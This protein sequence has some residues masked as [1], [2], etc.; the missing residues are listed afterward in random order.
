MRFHLTFFL[1]QKIFIPFS[2]QYFV[3]S[4]IYKVLQSG[5]SEFARFLHNEGIEYKGKSYKAFVFSQLTA[6]RFKVIQRKGLLFEGYIYLK[7]ASPL[8]EFNTAFLSGV[9]DVPLRMQE[10]ELYLHNVSVERLPSFEREMNYE[11]LSP[12]VFA[13]KND[14]KLKYGHPLQQSFYQGI[15]QSTINRYLAICYYK[16]L[17]TDEQAN[18]LSIEFINPEQFSIR[19]SAKLIDYKGKKIKGYQWPV[20]IEASNELHEFIYLC[21]VSQYVNQG[22]GMLG[23]KETSRDFTS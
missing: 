13:Y 14:Q 19:K 6:N 8:K 21:G 16:K 2:Y 7:V 18:R 4:W 22:F 17:K 12:V 15:S 23:L 11:L 9:Y 3:S 20:R 1:D 5:D 10:K